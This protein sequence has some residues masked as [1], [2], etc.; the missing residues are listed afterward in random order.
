MGMHDPRTAGGTGKTKK[1]LNGSGV[2]DRHAWKSS[3]RYYCGD[4]VHSTNGK[5]KFRWFTPLQSA[6]SGG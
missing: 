6:G 3:S 2:G 1:L 4:V 5:E